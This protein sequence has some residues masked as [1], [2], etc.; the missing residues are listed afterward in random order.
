MNASVISLTNYIGST[1]VSCFGYNDGS[2]EVI[3]TGAHAPYN[4]QWFGPNGFYNTSNILS[5]LYAE[6]YSVTVTDTNNCTVNTS[7][8]LT[9]PASLIFT[10]LFSTDANCLGACDGTVGVDLNGGTAPYFGHAQDNNTGTMLMNPLSGDSL[11]NGVCAGDHTISLS[12]ANGCPSHLL[13]GGNDQQNINALDTIEVAIDPLSC[14]FILCHGDTTGGVFMDWL[15]YDSSH[16]Y[17]WYE[18][19]DP[20]ISLGTG[21]NIVNL[22]V[23][24]YVLEANYFGCRATDTMILT[25]PAPIQISGSIT[26]AIC[27]GDNNG[28]IDANVSGG[29]PMP[30]PNLYNYLWSNNTTTEDLTN[31]LSGSYTLTVSDSYGCSSSFSFEVTEPVELEVTISETSPFVLELLSVNGGVPSYSYAWWKEQTGANQQVGIGTSYVV[32]SFGTYYLEVT[33]SYNCLAESNS[34]TY[35]LNSIV[36][37]QDVSFKVYPNPFREEATID[38]GYLVTEAKLSIVDVYGKLIEQHDINNQESFV[39]TNKNKASG[40]YFLKMEAGDRNMFVKLIIE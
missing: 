7:M 26:D 27:Y 9:E 35:S 13:V 10:T 3:T 17:N 20:T 39:I 30:A 40:I 29:T 24:S 2:V 23:G 14:F 11:F 34:E 19:N 15:T 8:N 37:G 22:G 5:A 21:T 1:D 6:T 4:Y 33:D 16:T 25:E 32:S 36:D 38:F 31:L 12:D 28:S 18:I